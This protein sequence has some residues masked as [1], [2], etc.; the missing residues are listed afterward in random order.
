MRQQII[1]GEDGLPALEVRPWAKDK[2][3]FLSYFMAIFNRGMKNKWEHR[4]YIDL[5][6]GPGRC[7]IKDTFMEIDGSPLCALN[8]ETPFTHHFFND[9]NPKSIEGIKLRARDF[10]SNIQ[11][12]NFDCNEAVDNILKDLPTDALTLAFI[13]PWNWEISFDAICR[14]T[15][16]RSMDLII[17]FHTGSIKRVAQYELELLESFFG[18]PEWQ[19]KYQEFIKAGGRQG[20]RILLDFYE[21]RLRNIAGYNFIDD[22]LFIT[23]TVEVPLYHLIYAS[24]HSIGAKFWRESIAKTRA[25][26]RRLL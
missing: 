15:T 25:G 3:Y 9:I 13:D 24:R 6:A 14:L 4:A 8:C 2:L 11:Y 1:Q 26:Q 5:F 17:T 18:D 7:R 21:N 12:Y 10:C 23:N 19:R 22:R 16:G 20:S